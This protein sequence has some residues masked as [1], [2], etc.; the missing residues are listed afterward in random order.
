MVQF[1]LGGYNRPQLDAIV[2]DV[3]TAGKIAVLAVYGI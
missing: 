3:N 2:G 1:V